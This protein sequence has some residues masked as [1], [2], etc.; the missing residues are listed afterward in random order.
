[1]SNLTQQAP[2]LESDGTGALADARRSLHQ[3]RSTS[4]DVIED[5][6]GAASDGAP[7]RVMRAVRRS[8]MQ[9]G[10]SALEPRSGSAEPRSAPDEPRPAQRGTPARRRRV[11]RVRSALDPRKLPQRVRDLSTEVMCLQPL[12]SLVERQVRPAARRAPIQ[13]GAPGG[14]PGAASSQRVGATRA[15]Q[16]QQQQ[17]QQQQ[18][19]LHALLA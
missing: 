1:M 9:I 17:Q 13:S 4:F 16:Q 6:C 12:R 8:E 11:E 14:A 5:S 15:V 2:V 3:R 19:G 18:G 7:G 10:G